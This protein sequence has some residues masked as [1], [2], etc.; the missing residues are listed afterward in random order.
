ML[1]PRTILLVDDHVAS[2]DLLYDMLDT[3]GHRVLIA[4]NGEAAV[5][6]CKL[7]KPDVIF[8]QTILSGMDGFEC[9]RRIKA[10]EDLDQTPVIMMSD[11]AEDSARIQCFKS[12]ACA[13]IAKPIIQDEVCAILKSQLELLDLREELKTAG[14]SESRSLGEFDVVVDLVA[15]D[16]KSPIVCIT[17]FA[18]ELA[19]QFEEVEVSP[20]WNEFLGFIHKSANDIDIIL[21]ALVLLKNLRIREWREPESIS[22][23]SVLSGVVSRYNQLEYNCPLELNSDFDDC[24]VLTQPALI[25]ELILILFRNFSNLVETEG[26]LKLTVETERTNARSILLRLNANTRSMNDAEL[27]YIL[28]PLH[29]RKRKRV[30]DANILLLCVQKMIAYLVMNAWA[31]HGPNNTL[32]ICLALEAGES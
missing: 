28:E 19:E 15:H 22:L 8:M 17:G 23:E 13:Y 4:E 7:A 10:D 27:T 29:G 11:E 26:P 30:K 31:E 3:L 24:T 20:E 14:R 1:K 25:E 16:M 32:T 12:G 5:R 18:E 9:C 2:L 6:R 21:E